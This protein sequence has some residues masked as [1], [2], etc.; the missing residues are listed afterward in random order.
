MA[1]VLAILALGVVCVFS[2]SASAD[3]LKPQERMASDISSRQRCVCSTWRPRT[4]RVVH[5][6]HYYYRV[7]SAYLIGYDVLPYRFGSTFVWEPPY[8]YY[9]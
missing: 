6:R 5:S 1:R 9:R 4:A 8:R 3:Q 2:G 7:R